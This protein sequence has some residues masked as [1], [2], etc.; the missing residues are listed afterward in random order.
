[1][2]ES[3]NIELSTLDVM[4]LNQI[5]L[6]SHYF[7]QLSLLSIFLCIYLYIFYLNSLS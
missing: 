3:C 1:M 2:Y 6:T 5:S 7:V 4:M